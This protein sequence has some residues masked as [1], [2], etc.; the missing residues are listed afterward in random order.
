MSARD[1]ILNKIRR[2]LGAGVGDVARRSIVIARL[3]GTPRSIVPARGQLPPEER[4]ALFTAYA[5]KVSATVGRVASPAEVPRAVAD[6]L[7]DRNLP[8]A[9]RMGDDPLL[10]AMPWNETQ[11]E[12]SRGASDGKDTV[13]VSHAAAGIAETGTLVL[14]SGPDN[15][16]TLNF[17]PEAHIVVV[18]AGD[19]VGDTETVWDR[20]R[21]RTGKGAMP[22]TVNMVTGPSRSGDIE[23]KI[24]LGAHGP[25]SL[26]IVVVG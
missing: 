4:I 15:P 2:S 20:L 13:A 11:I 12:L 25:R 19:I 16:T 14:A 5:E 23:Q 22:R 26:H 7:R 10:A 9:A 21:A 18:E 17:L 1:A 24:L 3:E 6:Y 8:A